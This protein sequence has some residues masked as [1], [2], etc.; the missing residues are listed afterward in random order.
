MFAESVVSGVMPKILSPL[1]VKVKLTK[2]SK[3]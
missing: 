2:G 1:T 3:T